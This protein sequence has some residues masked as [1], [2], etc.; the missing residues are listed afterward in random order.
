MMS[1]PTTDLP[2]VATNYSLDNAK[3]Q[4]QVGEWSSLTCLGS[5]GLEF[6][7]NR[8]VLAL[9]AGSA[10]LQLGNF[11]FAKEL[12]IK[13]KQ[14]GVSDRLM[15]R[16]LLSGVKNS[17]ASGAMAV[18]QT[19][20]A[21]LLT[22]EALKLAL[23]DE[24]V[25]FL[26]QRRFATQDAFVEKAFLDIRDQ[27]HS[28]TTLLSKNGVKIPAVIQ[29]EADTCLRAAD[30][31]GAI[32]LGVESK[33]AAEADRFY[34]YFAIAKAFKV[35]GD[36][37]SAL[38]FLNK[39]SQHSQSLSDAW[40]SELVRT[41]LAWGQK[42]L[43]AEI[44]VK[45]LL[46][47]GALLDF[48]QSE[49]K[50]LLSSVDDLKKVH[51]GKQM[52]GQ[53]LL[54]SFLDRHV[55]KLIKRIDHKPVILEIGTTREDV[56]GQGST[57]QFMQFCQKHDLDFVTVDMD[58]AN[59]HSAQ[60]MFDAAGTSFRA[61]T[62]K[63]EEFLEMTTD[64]F[65]FIFLDAYDFDHGN[66]SD[67]RQNRYETF[68]GDSISDQACHEMHL[69]CVQALTD[70]LPDH[71]LICFDDTWLEDGAWTAK[72]TTAM[73]YLL[74]N[75]FRLLDVRNRAALLAKSTFSMFD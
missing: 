24:D 8:E 2:S 57:K 23:P 5:L 11:T 37:M 75:G 28:S 67:L 7:E 25:R 65:D 19:D 74:S 27:K 31:V 10:G 55:S 42:V 22:T 26:A 48:T 60:A 4:W 54:L 45:A 51:D 21:T 71:G 9:L 43:A 68:L 12:L 40:R 56:P 13:A 39:A 15:A 70:K 59:S 66:H 18:Q 32:Q 36:G 63:G 58:P 1:A 29:V 62:A 41:Y 69:R 6:Q 14:W 46:Q 16:V 33:F 30:V 38:S 64:I 34:F 17:L 3:F 61:V 53:H 47:T 50:V 35:R 44:S 73:P 52:H 72:G 20:A 49:L